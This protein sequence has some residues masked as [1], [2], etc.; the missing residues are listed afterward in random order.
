MIKMNYSKRPLV[1]IFGFV[2][3]LLVLFSSTN[4]K[5]Y[6]VQ[7]PAYYC[8]D[9]NPFQSAL[10]CTF[11]HSSFPAFHD[12]TNFILQMGTDT[13][14]LAEVISGA[15]TYT[16]G[17][18][19]FMRMT[20]T[21]PAAVHGFELTAVDSTNDAATGDGLEVTNFAILNPVTT[22]LTSVTYNFVSHHNANSNRIWTF[23][24]TA[25]TTYEGPVTFYYA[26]NAGVD[27][28]T[29]IGDSIFVAT[30]TIGWSG[31]SGIAQI[32]DKLS[33]LSVFPTVF[34]NHVQVSFT[35]KE[36]ARV[37]ATVID[38]SGQVVKTIFNEGMSPGSFN[39]SVDLSSLAQGIYMVKVQIGNGYA[40]SKIVKQ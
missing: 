39:Q 38:M 33:G 19:Y 40:V 30:K 34:D 20:A 1:L 4:V 16:P 11:C 27:T 25:P 12:S 3:F 13:Q 6:K 18:L 22:A 15:T 7:P 8:N 14:S 5:S 29:N 24:W 10:N 26:G 2:A 23:T 36:N 31:I 37:Q 28:D 21:S 32:G 9:P 17:V 35:M